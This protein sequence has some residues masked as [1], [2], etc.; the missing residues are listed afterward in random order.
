MTRQSRTALERA[1]VEIDL[2]ALR[3]NAATIARRAGVPIVPMIK[4]D[5]YGLGA[6]AVARALEPLQPWG[7]GLATIAAK[8]TRPIWIR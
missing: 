3:Q 1:W 5:A 6:E 7:Y 2:G 4:A 8:A